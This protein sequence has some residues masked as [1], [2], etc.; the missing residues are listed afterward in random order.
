MA[1]VMDGGARG[2]YSEPND[3]TTRVH[4]L[5]EVD[6]KDHLAYGWVQALSDA[7]GARYL[8]AA[9][10]P[11]PACLVFTRQTALA[12]VDEGQG[13]RTLPVELQK[14]GARLPADVVTPNSYVFDVFRVA[15][16]KLHSYPCHGTIN[17]AFEWNAGGATPVE[18]LEKK[19]GETDTEAQ[20][21]S[22]VSLSKNQKFAGNAPDLLQATWRQVRFEKDTKGGVSEE[23][24]LGVNFNPSSP[25]WHTRWHLLG[26]SGRRALRAQVVM[27]KSGYQ[28]T[29]LMVWN[30]SGGRP[31]DAAYP[32]LVEPYVGEP[33]ITAQRE[34][35]V[36]PNEADALR[37]AAVEVQTRNGYQDVCFADGRPEKTRAFRTAWGA[38][39]VA[40][41]F[42]FA[43]RDAQGLRLTALTGG[44]LLETPDLR[45]ALAGRE[46]TGQITKVDYLRKTFWT[47]KP[48]PALCAGQ[49]LEVQSPGCPTSYTIAS[50]APDGAGS[51]IVVT[52]GAD[53]YRAP[54]TQVLPEQRR[55]DG[56]LPLPARRASIRGMTASNDAMTRLWRIENNSGNDF[57]LEGGGT[58][59]ADFAP[60]NALRISEYGVGD[61]VRLA[62]WAAIRRAGANRLE[63][64]AN[65]DLSLSLKGG[66]VEL[67]ADSKT[68]LPCAGGEVAIK[69]ADLAKGPVHDG[70][71]LEFR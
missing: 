36:E 56:R 46:Y 12:D 42:A 60:S 38:C 71:C 28:W 61:R 57:T 6:G 67:C 34:L 64:T 62:A 43:S 47:D 48:W 2:G 15:G 58:R 3:R 40:G 7:P 22:L 63:V 68:W 1:M 5:V 35:P 69:A 21:L 25:P 23:S 18:H 70:R 10:L 16:G 44:T 24:I 20:Y 9:A 51:R 29:A 32:A 45:I 14:P 8:R 37:A 30:R 55:V 4:N 66:W 54:I 33:F 27:H 50:V 41:E 39:R 53:F 65:S 26:T 11:P 59:S 17:D 49:V 13:S 31:V 19:T 52:N